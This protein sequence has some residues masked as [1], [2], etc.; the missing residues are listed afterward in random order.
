MANEDD[1]KNNVRELAKVMGLVFYVADTIDPTSPEH[2]PLWVSVQHGMNL[3]EDLKILLDVD[4][5]D[6][7]FGGARDGSVH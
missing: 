4:E 2:Y 5:V 1:I 6:F 3:I 7:E